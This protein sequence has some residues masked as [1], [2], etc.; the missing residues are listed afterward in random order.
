MTEE[1]NAVVVTATAKGIVYH[2]NSKTTIK[3]PVIKET[4]NLTTPENRKKLVQEPKKVYLNLV[5]R[6]MYRRLMYGMKEYDKRQILA[7]SQNAI[8]QVEEDYKKAKRAI[9]ILKAKKCFMAE[10]KLINAIFQRNIG[11]HDYDWYL[12]LP[13]SFTLR[14]LGI[15]TDDII[16]DFIKRKLLP[17]NFYSLNA[18]TIKL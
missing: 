6:Q 13:K 11:K 1:M 3:Y 5:Q 8:R 14:K 18:D 4:V 16:N 12:D 2:N 7:M 10:T 17:R 9:H 15:S